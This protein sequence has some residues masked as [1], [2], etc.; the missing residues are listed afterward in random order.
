VSHSC[1]LCAWRQT[2]RDLK[3]CAWILERGFG[4]TH[5]DAVTALWWVGAGLLVSGS[6]IIGKRGDDVSV[7]S[8]GKAAV[9]KDDNAVQTS[10]K[11]KGTK[12]GGRSPRS[13]KEASRGSTRL[14]N[15]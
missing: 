7:A 10:A 9:S 6:V 15:R 13:D 2:I 4:T 11:S 14:R 12:T 3:D 8:S 1:H 5:V